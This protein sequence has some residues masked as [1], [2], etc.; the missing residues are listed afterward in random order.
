MAL[1]DRRKKL[2][3][4]ILDVD[5][6]MQ[7]TLTFRDPVNLRINGKFEGNLDTRGNLIIS[8]NAIVKADIIG[9]NIVIAGKVT[10]TVTAKLEL[11]IIPPAVMI[12]NIKTPRLNISEGAILQG[13]CQ[14]VFER[15][16]E[17]LNVEELARYLEVDISSVLEWADSGKIPGFK[18]DNEWKFDRARIDE[19]VASGKIH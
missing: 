10:G 1:R 8:E 3:E 9:E 13:N 14:M 5:A 16:E 7:G 4:K 18:E 15:G 6:T 11:K 17:T 2:E 12:G 19:W